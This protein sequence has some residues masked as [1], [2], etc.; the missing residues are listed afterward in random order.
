MNN[1]IVLIAGG[2]VAILVGVGIWN[3]TNNGQLKLWAEGIHAT[4]FRNGPVEVFSTA[5]ADP[6]LTTAGVTSVPL[7]DGSYELGQ[8]QFELVGDVKYGDVSGHTNTDGGEKAVFV[9][10]CTSN[11]QTSQVLFVYGLENGKPVRLATANLSGSGNSLVQSYDVRDGAIQIKQNQGDPPKL[12]T[13]SYALLNGN[14]TS[15][16]QAGGTAVAQDGTDSG[17]AGTGT[18]AGD[19]KVSYQYFEQ[20]LTPYGTWIDH[21]RWGH[22]WH[23]TSVPADFR[24]Y[25]NGHWENTEDYGTV[26]VSDYAWGDIAFHYGRWGY[27]PSYGWLWVPGYV[28]GP[29]WVIWR[30][31]D[32]NIGW[33]PMPPGDYDGE[34]D[35]PDNFNAWYGYRDLYGAAFDAAAF[36][37]MWSFVPAV[38]IFEPGINTYIVDRGR[39]GAFIGR[40]AGWTRY[41]V[42]HGHV[43]NRSIDPH[44]FEAAF[45]HPMPLGTRHDFAAHHGL[46]TSFAGGHGIEQREHLAGHFN[47][48]VSGEHGLGVHGTTMRASSHG[49]GSSGSGLPG[50][51]IGFGTSG[52][53]S[54]RSASHVGFGSAAHNGF[55]STSHTGFG[56]T[57]HASFGSTS[58]SSFG[59]ASH[60]SFGGES[61]SGFGSTAHAGFGGE[62]HSGF[63]G[64]AHPSFGGGASAPAFGGSTHPSFGGAPST[65]VFGGTPRTAGVPATARAPTVQPRT[66]TCKGKHC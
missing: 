64:S 19:D 7:H 9:G 23:P 22:V 14:L 46:V 16:G 47:E 17:A 61:Q 51:H 15:L 55:G 38:D 12:S 1:R 29:S 41:G 26:W 49:F 33:F 48:R 34:G 65:G 37:A 58:H 63:G 59:S 44:R 4:D 13:L 21:P 43:F 42:F 54:F 5:C 8:Y 25:Q 30:A 56:S 62:T 53:T 20:K 40:T 57:S 10:S 66:S 28:W 11:G 6:Q 60:T 35:Y 18:A 24:P 2:A 36:Y 39:Y 32:G 27:D 45:H 52:H 31:G 3:W 50:A